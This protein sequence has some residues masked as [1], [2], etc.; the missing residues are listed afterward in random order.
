MLR[1][2]SEDAQKMLI[3]YRHTN[4]KIQTAFGQTQPIRS[5]DP[6]KQNQSKASPNLLVPLN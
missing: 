1:R 3:F 5:D 6:L 4:F 2:S